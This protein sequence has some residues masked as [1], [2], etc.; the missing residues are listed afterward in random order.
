MDDIDL[1]KTSLY[2]AIRFK[3]YLVNCGLW[4]EDKEEELSKKTDTDIKV[5][6]NKIVFHLFNFFYL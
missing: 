3:S 5:F 1:W 2:P 4:D 6:F